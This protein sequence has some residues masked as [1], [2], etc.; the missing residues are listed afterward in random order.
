MSLKN[1]F[2][3]CFAELV[4]WCVLSVAY[5]FVSGFYP[6]ALGMLFTALFIPGNGLMFA[7]GLFV[8]LVLLR[9]AGPRAAWWGALVLGTLF[10]LVLLLDI[11]VYSQYRFHL[12]ISML[13]LFFGPAGREIFVFPVSMY[14]LTAA[15][16]LLIVAATRALAG[17][18]RKITWGRKAVICISVLSVLIFAGYNGLYAWGKFMASPAV[19]TQVTYLPWAQPF[20]MNR[21]LRKMGFEPKSNPYSAPKSGMLRYPLAPLNC[22]PKEK[23]N[24]L[25]V[26]IDSWRADSFTP[27]IMPHLYDA[28]KN[29]PN[30]FYFANHLS[31]GNAT[32]AG[33]FSLMYSIPYSYWDTVTAT[34]TRPVLM[35]EL[36]KQGYDLAVYASGRL[37]SPEFNQNVFSHIPGLRINSDGVEKWQRDEDAQQDFLEFLNGRNPQKPFFGFLFYDSAHGQNFPPNYRAPFTPYSDQMNYLLLTKNTEPT[38]YM[39]RYK[40]S[41]H[42]IDSLIGQLF[43]ELKERGLDQNTIIIVSGDHGQEINDTRHNFWGHNSNFAKY[44]TRVPLLVWWPGMKGGE[45]AYRTSHYDIVPALLTHALNC[46]NPTRNYSSGYDLFS[47]VV[48]PWTLILSYTNKAVREGNIISVLN[49]YGGIT[50]YDENF[51]PSD[52]PVSASALAESLKE[53]SRFYK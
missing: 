26:L 39:N 16:I 22:L 48:R 49:N 7:A 30:A 46:S 40:N 53:F 9:C 37:D 34:K 15:A 51:V 38:P 3:F 11:F 33:V 4:L 12:S 1:I 20:S 28:Y 44:Q 43:A 14:A 42:Y 36:D 19:L 31:G 10:N 50:N 35:D 32:E 27:Q 6:T 13:Q 21:R 45:K 52:S 18:A 17:L 25:L 23:P 2:W 24:I 5:F 41:V 47:S 29:S 8:L